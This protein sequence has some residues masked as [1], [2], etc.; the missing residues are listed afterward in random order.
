MM[1]LFTLEIG[2][3]CHICGAALEFI[4]DGEYVWLGC[5]RC[6]RYV[7]KEKRS[8]VRRYFDYRARRIDWRTMIHELYEIYRG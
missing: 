1:D 5:R 8:L 4:E 6:M 7:K 2:A 3:R